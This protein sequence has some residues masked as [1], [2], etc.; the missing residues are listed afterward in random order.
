M[1]PQRGRETLVTVG[2]FAIILDPSQRVL[3]CHRRDRDLWNLPGGGVERGES[4]WDAV[5]REV[6]E[7]TG[8]TVVVERL[9]GIY[10]QPEEDDLAFAFCCAITGGTPTLT[11]EADAITYFPLDALP[12]NTYHRHVERVRDTLQAESYVLKEQRG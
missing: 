8:L 3:L 2:S 7:E 4:P 1:A 11:D 5:V 10:S 12:A 6:A 9:I